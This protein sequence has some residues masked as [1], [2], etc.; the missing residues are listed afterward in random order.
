MR[1]PSI[2]ADGKVIIFEHDFGIWKMDV[3][4][5][6]ASPIALDIAA[7]TQDNTSEVRTFNSEAD[8]YSLDPSGRRI[9]LSV[10]GEVF[11]APTDQGDLVQLTD[12]AARDQSAGVFARR[13]AGSPTFRT[14]SG[15]EE[16][17]VVVDRRRRR[18]RARSP[19][20]MP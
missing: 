2:S 4:S 7:E 16:I 3:A 15:R 11:T 9:A 8:D 10:Y 17:Y 6:K 5:R 18:R 14:R 19:M 12:G 1:W 20:S 13:Q